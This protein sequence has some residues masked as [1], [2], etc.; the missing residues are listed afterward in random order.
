MD[1]EKPEPI[2]NILKFEVLDFIVTKKREL[3]KYVV[4]MTKTYNEN[5]EQ[6]SN[7]YDLI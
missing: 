3:N 7:E 6:L 5:L 4:D 1:I 2:A